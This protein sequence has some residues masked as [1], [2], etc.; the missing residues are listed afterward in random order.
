MKFA[1]KYLKGTLLKMPG[2]KYPSAPH[3]LVLVV[4]EQEDDEGPGAKVAVSINLEAAPREPTEIAIKD[5]SEGE[6]NLAELIR[7]GVVSPPH[8]YEQSGYVRVP[9][10]HLQPEW[11]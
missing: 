6:G 2:F 1:A 7:L 9:I 10:C 4:K 8:R 5:Y 3:W 11:R